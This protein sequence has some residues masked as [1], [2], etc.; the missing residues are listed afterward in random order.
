MNR[1]ACVLFSAA[2]L[3]ALAWGAGLDGADAEAIL[4]VIGPSSLAVAALFAV[5]IIFIALFTHP[6]DAVIPSQFIW[7]TRFAYGFTMAALLASTLPFFFLKPDTRLNGGAI[8]I[9]VGCAEG[10]EKNQGLP[11]EILCDKNHRNRLWLVNVGG[12][13]E[14]VRQSGNEGGEAASAPPILKI[15][16]G[17]VVPLYVLVLALMGAAVSMTRRVPEYQWRAN[18][19]HSQANQ[20]NRQ[21]EPLSFARARELMVFQIMQ[22]ISA[23][24]IAL[25]AYY[26][27]LP[28]THSTS[29]VIGFVSGFASETILR[30]L[31]IPV[32][33][34]TAKLDAAKRAAAA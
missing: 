8:G 11:L 5:S 17:L 29:V 1:V 12:S 25:T 3:P 10:I 2:L 22:V 6:I 4:G 21:Q 7:I 23:P 24:M 33:G 31:R 26:L 20:T 32:D 16:G 14:F 19:A 9:A 15:T 34:L 13:T 30:L 28:D 18:G 27:V